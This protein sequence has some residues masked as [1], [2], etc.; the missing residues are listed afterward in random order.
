MK[1]VWRAN[2]RGC[3]STIADSVALLSSSF[4]C[5]LGSKVAVDWSVS[6]G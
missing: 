2:M 4:C 5:L 1:R 6:A 3:G